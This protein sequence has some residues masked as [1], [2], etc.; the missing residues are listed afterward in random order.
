MVARLVPIDDD[1]RSYL[2]RVPGYAATKQGVRAAALHHPDIF[3]A[4][5]IGDLHVDPG[6]RVD[7]LDLDHLSLEQSRPVG[8]ELAAERM[9]RH[10]RQRRRQQNGGSCNY[11]Q[12]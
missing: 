11:R 1:E 3:R 10:Q 5:R 4:V 2:K 12:L 6:M 8:I 9:M 7:P